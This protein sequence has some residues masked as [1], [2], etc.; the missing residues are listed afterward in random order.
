VIVEGHGA[1]ESLR[2]RGCRLHEQLIELVH[3]AEGARDRF[4]R[5]IHGA[6]A[7]WLRLQHSERTAH[8]MERRRSPIRERRT[9]RGLD[10]VQSTHRL[11]NGLGH[12]HHRRRN[13]GRLQ[14]GQATGEVCAR[15]A[16]GAHGI[17]HPLSFQKRRRS[18]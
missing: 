2:R 17:R 16:R 18:V 5:L 15:S 10:L 8:G 13:S 11:G 3:Q 14:R 9:V 7:G 1:A 6:Q 12:V 4:D